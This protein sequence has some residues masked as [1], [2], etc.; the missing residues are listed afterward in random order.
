MILAF[1]KASNTPWHS[2]IS[3]IQQFGRN[4]LNRLYL[5]GLIDIREGANCKVIKLK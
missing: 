1:L 4:E 5:E 2:S 3:L